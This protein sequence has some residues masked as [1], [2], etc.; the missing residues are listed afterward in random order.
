MPHRKNHKSGY[1]GN[2]IRRV[3]KKSKIGRIEGVNITKL[4]Y[5]NPFVHWN[6]RITLK[7][8]HTISFISPKQHRFVCLI[9]KMWFQVFLSMILRIE[10]KCLLVVKYMPRMVTTHDRWTCEEVESWHEADTLINLEVDP[11]GQLRR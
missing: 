6:Q 8:N 4:G 9:S 11:A 10:G 7:F 1:E 2:T 5:V 3:N